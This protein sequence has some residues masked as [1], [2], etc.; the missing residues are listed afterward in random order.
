VKRG[1]GVRGFLAGVLLMTTSLAALLTWSVTRRPPVFVTGSGP[2]PAAT[3]PVPDDTAGPVP[4]PAPGVVVRDDDVVRLR[5]RRLLLPVSGVDAKGLRD[6]FADA[7]SG[8][9]HDAMDIPAPRGTP[10]LAADDGIV[11]KLFTSRY[12]G[13]TVYQFDPTERYCYY[14]AHLDRY[15]EGLS[16]GALVRQGQRIGYV[17]TSGNAPRQTP[18]LHFAI[19]KLGPEKR[20]WEG[21][22]INPFSVWSGGVAS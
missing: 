3:P 9:R 19:F 18:H 12:G 22:A 8:H 1:S 10:V 16:E 13:I 5:D 7:R 11:R 21:V 17:G 6:T 20:W 2:P 15:A 4:S 14:Y